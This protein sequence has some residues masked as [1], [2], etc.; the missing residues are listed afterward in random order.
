[1][2]KDG[3]SSVARWTSSKG[4]DV[5]KKKFIFIPVQG[6]EHWALA[7]VV[8]AGEV[9][10]KSNNMACLIYLNSLYNSDHADMV[11]D[12]VRKWLSSEWKR[13]KDD[14]EDPFATEGNFLLFSPI[15][16]SSGSL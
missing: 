5:F 1:L 10:S 12:H 3:I 6:K 15:G 7:V 2:E 13:L 16:L 8:N 11:H 9:L 14:G 4:I